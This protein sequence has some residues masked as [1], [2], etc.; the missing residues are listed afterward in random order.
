MKRVERS[1]SGENRTHHE[2]MWM[3]SQ[4]DTTYDLSH[5]AVCNVTIRWHKMNKTMHTQ[6]FMLMCSVWKTVMVVMSSLVSV[7]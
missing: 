7:V 2:R 3:R 6:V 5:G 4:V 1:M